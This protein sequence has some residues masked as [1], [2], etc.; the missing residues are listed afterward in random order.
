[1]ECL[2]HSLPIDKYEIVPLK[3]KKKKKEKGTS[4]VNTCADVFSL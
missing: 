4:R 2:S 1:M 3:K